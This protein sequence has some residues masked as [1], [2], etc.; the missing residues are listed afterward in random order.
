MTFWISCSRSLQKGL[1]PVLAIGLR[2]VI[3]FVV[4]EVVIVVEIAAA[5]WT[6]EKGSL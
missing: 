4:E 3:F 6:A 5:A 1:L 2:F